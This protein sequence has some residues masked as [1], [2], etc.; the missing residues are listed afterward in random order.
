MSMRI[1]KLWIRIFKAIIGNPSHLLFLADLR[2]H[3]VDLLALLVV[4]FVYHLYLL[5]ERLICR[6]FDFK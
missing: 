6:G 2:K 1:C 5:K 3:T 4:Y